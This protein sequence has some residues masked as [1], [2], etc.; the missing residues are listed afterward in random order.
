MSGPNQD[1][2]VE[3]D[4]RP[5]APYGQHVDIITPLPDIRGAHKMRIGPNG[6]ILT[7]EVGVKGGY[8]YTIQDNVSNTK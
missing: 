6:E 7:E 1:V 8:R 5:H 4:R 2:K 3:I